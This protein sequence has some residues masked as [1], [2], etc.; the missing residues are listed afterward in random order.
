M[1]KM[2]VKLQ[3]A[4][5]GGTGIL[6]YAM[7]YAEWSLYMKIVLCDDSIGDLMKLEELVGAYRLSSAN[8]Y[9]EVE[10]F[11][12]ASDLLDEIQKEEMADIYILDIVMSR[13]TGIDLG[14][15]IRKMS[16]KS[17]II[18]VT[19]SDDFALDAYDVHAIRYLLKPVDEGKFFEAMD[20]ALAQIDAEE[21]PLFL[22]KTKEGMVSVPYY[23]IEYIENSSRRLEIHLTNRETITSIFI[24]KSFD[25][26][27]K[28][29]GQNRE[30]MRVHKSYLV[31]MKHVKGMN[32]ADFV[33]DS[34]ACSPISRKSIMEA[35]KGFCSFV[36]E[37]YK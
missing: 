6:Q 7:K 11:S 23:K 10:K 2:D 1:W 17:V 24:R 28:D 27:I 25:E 5:W 16:S 4:E 37:H 19:A 8:G 12:D 36:A 32:K 3:Y 14:S 31:N 33:M 22:V 26:E 20:Y 29:F 30:F 13:I 9:L 15:R 21:G 35:R 18:Y 34:G